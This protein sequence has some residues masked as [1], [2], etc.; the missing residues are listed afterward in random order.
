MD[1]LLTAEEVAERLGMRAD[2]AW[3]QARAGGIRR[4]RPGR[5]RSFRAS[6]IEASVLDEINE[7][8][9]LTNSRISKPEIW[10]AQ[11]EAV[12]AIYRWVL[13]V[14]TSVISSNGAAVFVDLLTHH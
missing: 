4:V 12:K 13:P 11:N 8:A 6:A 1:W 14:F 7:R 3:A 5:Y 10:K 2:W 9:E